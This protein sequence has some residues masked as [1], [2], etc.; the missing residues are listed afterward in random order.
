[1]HDHPNPKHLSCPR[2]CDCHRRSCWPSGTQPPCGLSIKR[3]PSGPGV[4]A[5]TLHR[6]SFSQYFV[7]TG[8]DDTATDQAERDVTRF[9]TFRHRASDFVILNTDDIRKTIGTVEPAACLLETRSDRRSIRSDDAKK[10]SGLNPGP[11]GVSARNLLQQSPK[12]AAA[13]GREDLSR[14]GL[15]NRR[16]G[17]PVLF[18]C[19]LSG[20]HVDN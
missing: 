14:R 5:G 1:M 6:N 9:L 18:H 15:R 16:R 19:H 10:G 13:D 17:R 8:I 3:M 12:L 2:Q 20:R 4:P 11:L 7:T